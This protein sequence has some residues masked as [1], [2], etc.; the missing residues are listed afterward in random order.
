MF[1]DSNVSNTCMIQRMGRTVIQ[2]DLETLLAA[3]DALS[4]EVTL[5]GMEV[6][7]LS[8]PSHFP[9]TEIRH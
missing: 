1:P 6:C 4:N 7:Y 9:T 8:E 2:T 5:L 3:L